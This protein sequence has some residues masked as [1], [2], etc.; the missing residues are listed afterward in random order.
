VE[1]H[2]D[3]QQVGSKKTQTKS[4][5]SSSFASHPSWSAP[6]TAHGECAHEPMS[7]VQLPPPVWHV[8]LVHVPEHVMPQP[9]QFASS[10]PMVSVQLPA[11]QLC[12]PHDGLPQPP[13][14]FGSLVMSTHTLLQHVLALPRHCPPQLL[15]PLSTG[16]VPVSLEGDESFGV[17]ESFGTLES[18]AVPESIVELSS[19][20]VPVAQPTKT[21]P[22]K[23]T[24]A[25]GPTKRMTPSP[26]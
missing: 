2:D 25:A 4:V 16:G 23:Q 22:K 15:P 8:P 5:M 9:P 26:S 24:Y 13:Q 14:L 6:P 7:I 18:F 17:L 1:S 12:E 11:Q 10:E 21:K 19:A 3:V 20:A